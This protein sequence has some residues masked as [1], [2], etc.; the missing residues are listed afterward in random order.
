MIFVEQAGKPVQDLLFGRSL[1]NSLVLFERT[2]AIR[3]GID[4]LAEWR[5]SGKI[6]GLTV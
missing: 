4:S 2:F 6:G 1:I 3:Q 5:A